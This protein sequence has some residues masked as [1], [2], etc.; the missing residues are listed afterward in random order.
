MI[1]TTKYSPNAIKGHRV[2]IQLLAILFLMSVVV[3]FATYGYFHGPQY[4]REVINKNMPSLPEPILKQEIRYIEKQNAIPTWKYIQHLNG[5]LNENTAKVIAEAVDRSHEKYGLPRKLIIA[6][7]KKESDLNPLARS[8]SSKGEILARG[9]MQVFAK[10]HPEK[11][12]GI[13]LEQLYHIDINTN[14]GCEI[15]R[16]YYD[17]SDGDLTETFHKYLSKRASKADA[18]K[19]M[20]EIL[21]WWAT[22]EMYE[23]NKE[24]NPQSKELEEESTEEKH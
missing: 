6:I 14:M 10:W 3:N 15:F 23:Y 11:M 24:A 2:G 8:R 1:Y 4:I 16:D 9:L 13:S 20:D 18:K 5:R 17:E 22:L 21:K 7:M 19:Y 12:K